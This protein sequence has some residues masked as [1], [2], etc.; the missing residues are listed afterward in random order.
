VSPIKFRILPYSGKD[1]AK[2]VEIVSKIDKNIHGLPKKDTFT[3][4]M[5]LE[6]D[7]S[8]GEIDGSSQ[9]IFFNKED[10]NKFYLDRFCIFPVQ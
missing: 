1:S 10:D 3:Y 9:L 2:F 5:S 7:D 6:L 4:Y 8:I